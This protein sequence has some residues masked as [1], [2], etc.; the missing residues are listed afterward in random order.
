MVPA[1]GQTVTGAGYSAPVPIRVAPGQ[2][3]TLYVP[4]LSSPEGIDVTVRQNSDYS[5]PVLQVTNVPGCDGQSPAK[6]GSS[7]AIKRRTTGR[8]SDSA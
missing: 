1:F 7:A 6:W 4:G 5:A 3:I 2:V 8:G